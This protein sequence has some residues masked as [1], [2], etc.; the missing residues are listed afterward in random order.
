MNLQLLIIHQMNLRGDI[1]NKI[2]LK[3]IIVL[4]IISS[5]LLV[6]HRNLIKYYYK[7]EASQILKEKHNNRLFVRHVFAVDR[8]NGFFKLHID[9]TK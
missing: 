7:Y 8:I 5:L 3:I 4:I 9:K 1:M 2:K 6:F